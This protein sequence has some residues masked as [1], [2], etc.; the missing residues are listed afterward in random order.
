MLE[1]R[2]IMQGEKIGSHYVRKQF[3]H[4]DEFRRRSDGVLEA[5]E[6]TLAP[7]SGLGKGVQ[8]VKRLMLG[9][10][11]ATQQQ[12]NERLTKVMA[13]AVLSSDAI[14]SVAYATEALS[15]ANQGEP[16]RLL[17]EKAR[18]QFRLAVSAQRSYQLSPRL[19]SPRILA[20]F[21]QVRAG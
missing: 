16:S 15:S 1:R 5:T 6:R 13:L 17:R 19:V 4:M 14:S 18:A 11:L 10:R 12:V 2:A 20:L 3:T 9:E 8:R 21:E 7:R